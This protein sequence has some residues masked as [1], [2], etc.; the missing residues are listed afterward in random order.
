MKALR[1]LE[2]WPSDHAVVVPLGAT[3][4]RRTTMLY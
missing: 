3:R 4:Q 1:F 2:V